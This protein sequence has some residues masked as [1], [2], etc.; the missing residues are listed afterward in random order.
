[1]ENIN[2]IINYMVNDKQFSIYAMFEW[3]KINKSPKE[4]QLI[5]KVYFYMKSS[6]I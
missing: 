3:S 6:S 2:I 1:M 5:K 4:L